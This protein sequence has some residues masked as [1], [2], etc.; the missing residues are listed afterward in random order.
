MSGIRILFLLAC[1]ILILLIGFTQKDDFPVLKG[2]YLGQK[3]PGMTPEIFVPGFISTEK[4]ELNSVFT[5]DEKEFYFSISKPGKGYTIMYTKQVK[6]Q[7]IKPQVAPFSG[8]YSDVDMCISH[9]GKRM[10][11]GSMRPLQKG[12]QKPNDFQIWYVEKMENGWSKPKNLGHPINSAKRALYPSITKDG[13]LYFQSRRSGGY[14]GTDIYRSELLN[15]TY[16]EPENLGDAI[17]SQYDE[18]DVFIAPDESFLIF[19]IDHPDSYGKGDL[20]ISFRKEDGSWTKAKNMGK[21][22]NSG[23][24]EYCPMLSPDGKYLFFSRF[25]SSN[26]IENSDIYWVD[27]KIIEELRPK[28]LK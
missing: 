24:W 9:D 5:P 1:F 17:N 21:T 27:A 19:S 11:F 18:G 4:R 20:Y 3:P 26:K 16:Q 23:A 14:G 2:P 25:F 8:E 6:E 10:F 22:I 12:G 28:E 7:W 15:G 13:T